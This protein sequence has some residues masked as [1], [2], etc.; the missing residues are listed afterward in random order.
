M[1]NAV[2]TAISDLFKKHIEP[3]WTKEDSPDVKKGRK[4]VYREA[5]L[6]ELLEGSS[7]KSWWA[8]K[9]V[10]EQYLF[11]SPNLKKASEEQKG[12]AVKA[13]ASSFRY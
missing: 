3:T 9:V 4:K 13:R 11:A 6:K 8:K 10:W 7:L 12:K 2:R 1:R 5:L